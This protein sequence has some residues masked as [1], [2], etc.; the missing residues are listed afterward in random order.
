M[1]AQKT[2]AAL[3]VLFSIIIIDLIGFGIVLPIL[4]A[5]AK[6]LDASPAVMGSLIA[7]HALFQFIFS[8][9]WGRLSD[10][11][12]RR[13]V[14][15]VTI[16]G[17]SLALL[18]LGLAPSL[19]WLFAA[20]VLSG[21]F[22]ANISVATAYIT[23]VT[24]ESE[25]TRWMG[26]V[27]AC[28]AIGFLL[29]PAIGGLL[30]VY[31][32]GTPMFVASA[33]AAINAVF[34]II[35]LKEPERR[36]ESADK[37]SGFA[38]GLKDP[39]IRR[40]CL[41]NFLFSLAVTQLETVFFYFMNDR[42]DYNVSQVAFVLVGMAVVMGAI[43]GGGMRALAKHVGEKLL[44]QTGLI[45]MIAG[46]FTIPSMFSVGMLV[47]P[48]GLCAVGRAIGQAPMT[49]MISL[50]TN[51][52]NRGEVMGAYQSAASLARVF[53]PIGAGIVYGLSQGYPF[54]VAAGFLAVA[55]AFALTLP[56][57]PTQQTDN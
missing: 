6:H 43:Q 57:P 22:G 9:I 49:S 39:I 40:I 8:P 51:E 10:R 7:T 28:F 36:G 32:L 12:G 46:F 24:E 14:I 54:Y 16:F 52:D 38:R 50:R 4:P 3:P 31:G 29:G 15:L 25:R 48:L 44:L 11:V 42:F 1:S 35:L 27:G 13:P 2:L 26:M 23:D 41:T 34:A 33:M 53:G 19:G 30:A 56:A 17:T 45:L 20:R 21:I 18:M 47:I 55:F 5:Y 37:Q